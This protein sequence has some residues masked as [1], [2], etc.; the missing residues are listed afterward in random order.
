MRKY[1]LLAVSELIGAN[2][3]NLRILDLGIPEMEIFI[4]QQHIKH[5]CSLAKI[6][7]FCSRSTCPIV[8]MQGAKFSGE[9]N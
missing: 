4:F 7:M 5:Q 1:I 8:L 6:L 9:V 2:F 3:W